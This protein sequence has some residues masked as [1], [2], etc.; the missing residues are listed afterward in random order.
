MSTERGGGSGTA[1]VFVGRAHVLAE[2]D[3]ALDDAEAER[4]SLVLVTGD[5][6]IGKTQLTSELAVRARARGVLVL[7]GTCWEGGGA[8]AYWPW[9]QVFRAWMRAANAASLDDLAVRPVDLAALVPERRPAAATTQPQDAEGDRFRLFDALTDAL[10]R[11]AER[12]PIL[13]V[14]DDLHWADVSSVLALRFLAGE[15]HHARLLVVGAYRD[16]E[17]GQGHPLAAALGDLARSARLLPLSGLARDEVA[18]F[19]AIITGVEPHPDLVGAVS[20][21]TG[22][23]PLFVRELVR[24]AWQEGSMAS[25]AAMSSAAQAMPAGVREVIARRLRLLEGDARAV[26]EVASVVGEAFTLEVVARTSGL[27]R[28]RLLCALEHAIDARLI[29]PEPGTPGRYRFA[30]ALIREVV[31]Q[32]LPAE[33]LAWLHGRTGEALEGLYGD[34]GEHLAAIASHY[35]RAAP[36]GGGERALRYAQRAGERALAMLAWEEAASHFERALG[37]CDLEPDVAGVDRRC[38]L[39]LALGRAHVWAESVLGISPRRADGRTGAAGWPSR[40][41][42]RAARRRPDLAPPAARGG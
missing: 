30:H 29:T 28:R 3:A 20:G 5:P 36:L 22:G 19:I 33:R 10:L 21:Q 24:L 31:Y 15:L 25:L 41:R 2:L 26:L 7:R 9:A 35:L 37:V 13:L 38:E 12:Q 6:G 11:G 14:L 23:N 42:P 18:R 8:P 4:G 16:V 34:A 39:H 32:R 27:D 1:G 17:V 40:F